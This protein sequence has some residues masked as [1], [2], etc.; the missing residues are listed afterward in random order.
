VQLRR[1]GDVLLTTPLLADLR[2]AFP[3]ARIDYLVGPAAAP[4]VA[5]NAD[6]SEILVYDERHPVRE[7][8]RLRARR[9]DWVID[10]QSN[11]RTAQIALLSG[12]RLRA[13][14]A[15]RGLWRLAYT[16]RLPRDGRA[17]EYVPRERQ[18]MLELLGVPIA[19]ARPRLHLTAAERAAGEAALAAAGIRAAAPVVGFTLGAGEPTKEWPPERWAEL[20]RRLRAR[21]VVPLLFEMPGEAERVAAFHAAAGDAVVV[22]LP[23]LRRFLGALPRADVFVAGDTG[24]AHMA[25][26]L[27]VPTVTLHGPTNPAN[28]SARL[29]TTVPLRRNDGCPVC[30]RR[31]GA[32]RPGHDCMTRLDVGDVERAVTALLD[33]PAGRAGA[34]AGSSGARA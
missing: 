27:D 31:G 1:L 20:S 21:G 13:G 8:R 30:A 4:L 16:H 28:W 14:W 11:P 6:A 5:G 26:A 34:R 3:E 17:P 23:E 7:I 12:A 18:R 32:N 10:L 33:R 9:Y 22:R 2:R 19:P 29:P 24:P 15:I 25:T